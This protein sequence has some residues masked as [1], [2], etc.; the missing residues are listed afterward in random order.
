MTDFHQ[1]ILFLGSIIKQAKHHTA[2]ADSVWCKAIRVHKVQVC[3]AIWTKVW[4]GGHG[5]FL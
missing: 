4:F 2:G 5:F 3:A 1:D